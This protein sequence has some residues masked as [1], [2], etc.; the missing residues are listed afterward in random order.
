MNQDIPFSGGVIHVINSVLNIPLNL[1]TTASAANLTAAAG[2]LTQADLGSALDN[3]E[4]IT[5][6]APNNDAFAA[7]G[8][9]LGDI[10]TEELGNI[11]Q[12]HVIDGTVGYSSSLMNGTLTTA[13]GE[14]VDVTVSGGDVFVDSARVVIPDVLLV[15]GVLHVI[16]RLVPSNP[17]LHPNSG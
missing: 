13:N 12:Y 17:F 4:N 6:F 9:I 3:M 2:A 1:T 11:L 10:S 7:I 14:D 5:V 8:S 16:D 15:N